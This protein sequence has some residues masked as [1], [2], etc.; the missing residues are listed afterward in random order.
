MSCESVFLELFNY[1]LVQLST[2]HTC[3]YMPTYTPGLAGHTP[4]YKLI[5][6]GSRASLVNAM[7]MFARGDIVAWPRHLGDALVD[8]IC[9]LLR[10]RNIAGRL[11][12]IRVRLGARYH[13]GRQRIAGTAVALRN[14]GSRPGALQAALFHLLHVVRILQREWRHH[15]TQKHALPLKAFFHTVRRVT[16]PLLNSLKFM[17]V[18][19]YS[20][21]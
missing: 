20:V 11:I 12:Q 2:Q 5:P 4:N 7:Q 19:T 17:Y 10:R 3:Y 14:S 1:F 13:R 18:S 15:A 21:E 9:A 16:S 8:D 6:F